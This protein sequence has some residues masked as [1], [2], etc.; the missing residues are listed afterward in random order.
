[1]TLQHD[2]LRGYVLQY[3]Q[4]RDPKVYAKILKRMDS[5]L[6]KTINVLK[7]KRHYLRDIELEELY[8]IGITGL[9]RA[10]L[11]SPAN[12]KADAFP[13]RV[14]A[15]IDLDTWLAFSYKDR[16]EEATWVLGEND[17]IY[18]DNTDINVLEVRDLITQM[19]TEKLLSYY[20]IVLLKDRFFEQQSLKVLGHNRGISHE[21]VRQQIMKIM[22]KMRE[23]IG[24][25]NKGE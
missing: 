18:E 23:Y 20:D 14:I 9:Y 16:P 5:L 13:A 7:R 21:W 1:M 15:Y 22:D 8:Q 17:V 2:I 24:N 4:T 19:Y 12:E 11:T 10:I 25:N 6:I 3:Q